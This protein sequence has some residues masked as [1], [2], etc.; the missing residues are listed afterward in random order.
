MHTYLKIILLVALSCTTPSFSDESSRM[1]ND[2]VLYDNVVPSLNKTSRNE[3]LPGDS[4]LGN[5]ESSNIES[6]KIKNET[7]RNA[8]DETRKQTT[9]FIDKLINDTN[10][11]ESE[12]ESTLKFDAINLK[13]SSLKKT[14]SDREVVFINK[15]RGN[16]GKRI[17]RRKN[18]SSKRVF[19]KKKRGAVFFG[20]N[21]KTKKDNK[22]S[23][24]NK[25][26][27]YNSVVVPAGSISFGNTMA[28]IQLAR[29]PKEVDTRL[30]GIFAGPNG[31][32][33]ELKGC[34]IW[35]EYLREIGTRRITSNE[36]KD[37]RLTCK[38]KNGKIFTVGVK[39][40][41]RDFNDEYIGAKGTLNLN[42]QYI[43]MGLRLV[44][45]I[46]TAFG[47][48]I[49]AANVTQNLQYNSESSS[50]QKSQNVTGSKSKYVTGKTINGATGKML[51][52]TIQ[53]FDGMEPTL[54]LPP[55]YKVII[56]IKHDVRIPKYFFV[57]ELKRSNWNVILN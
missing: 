32:Y 35:V 23:K 52:K 46:S 5:I 13:Q 8:I 22:H 53:I 56:A 7:L 45:G 33:V 40:Q 28:G 1:N 36:G 2:V 21:S 57:P 41:V 6:V 16:T 18:K 12:P 17:R 29:K 26:T 15:D 38:A 42:N 4:V 43:E 39:V 48:A 19:R 11:S 50:G 44:K 25:L 9:A 20:N 55:G 51:D 31:A 37:G 24:S 3:I 27:D 14:I 34:H 30:R 47:Q 10:D 49:S 54:D